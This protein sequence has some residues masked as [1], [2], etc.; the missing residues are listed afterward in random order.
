MK[1]EGIDEEKCIKLIKVNMKEY[2]E[3]H[4]EN[5]FEEKFGYK[6]IVMNV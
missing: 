6:N 4:Y 1:F 5:M 2:D 3:N